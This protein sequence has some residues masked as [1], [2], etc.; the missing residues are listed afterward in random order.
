MLVHFRITK[1]NA[2]LHKPSQFIDNVDN[3]TSLC[4]NDNA[5]NSLKIILRFIGF[6]KN[7]SKLKHAR[8]F[9]ITPL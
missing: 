2:A 5:K 6:I 8:Y 1:Y 7:V 9:H 3:K 4:A